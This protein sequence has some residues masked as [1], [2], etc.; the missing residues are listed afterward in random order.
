MAKLSVLS[1]F[2]GLGGLDFGLLKTRRFEITL[3]VEKDSDACATLHKNQTGEKV[4]SAD[5]S[6]LD[7]SKFERPDVIVGGP[8]CQSF[9][10]VGKRRGLSDSR[11]QML[12]QFVRAVDE[13]R[14]RA[15]VMENVL[16]LTWSGKPKG[17]V[18]R[19]FLRRVPKE[20]CVKCFTVNAADYGA[21]QARPRLIVI[22]TQEGTPLFITPTHGAGRGQPHKT[23]GDA[24]KD[25][26]PDAT[27]CAFNEKNIALLS[28][29]PPGKN[30]RTLPKRLHQQVLGGTFWTRGGCSGYLR[31]LTFELPCPTLLG[32]PKHKSTLLCHPTRTRP[33]NI[34]EYARIQGFPDSWQ[35]C[36]TK[37]KQYLQI[38]NA[39]P[40]ALGRAIGLSILA[41][42]KC[43]DPS[44]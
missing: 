32:S 36:G 27:D 20:Y 15:F 39:V 26:D 38:G 17:A 42:L 28:R 6:T 13:L 31:R 37:T 41:S 30:W 34:R 10:T 5:I 11:G 24:I 25:L 12:W 23:L 21:P 1:L 29:I 18:L 7:F 35:F 43:S 40:V 14:P 19:Q 33:L 2:S 16:G 4:L 8:P 9:S 22:G 44:T 3:Q